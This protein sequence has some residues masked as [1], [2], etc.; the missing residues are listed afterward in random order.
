M[1][2][3]DY[4]PGRHTWSQLYYSYF[5]SYSYYS[6][7]YYS[8]E[9][10]YCKWYSYRYYCF[11]SY[12]INSFIYASLKVHLH[13]CRAS[14]MFHLQMSQ[15]YKKHT[16][17]LTS[18]LHTS[19]YGVHVASVPLVSDE[20]LSPIEAI[21]IPC[22][23]CNLDWVLRRKGSDTLCALRSNTTLCTSC[24]WRLHAGGRQASM[25]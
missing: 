13:V 5:C 19:T 22:L 18:A 15:K 14:C 20:V 4:V 11:L 24:T 25:S 2:G 1:F 16:Y 6:Y 8:F 7:Y 9:Y 23:N 10:S 17:K 21:S 3:P 12:Y